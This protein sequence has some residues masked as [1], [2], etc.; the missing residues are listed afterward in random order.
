MTKWQTVVKKTYYNKFIIFVIP[1]GPTK[2]F[3]SKYS[4]IQIILFSLYNR[5]QII[6]LKTFQVC[7]THTLLFSLLWYRQTSQNVMAPKHATL[8]LDSHTMGVS[9]IKTHCTAV[10]IAMQAK[11]LT[12]GDIEMP[13]VLLFCFH[14]AFQKTVQQT[15]R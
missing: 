6:A 8:I 11:L 3:T 10:K 15:C 12:L 13:K 5:S 7:F 2:H 9:V 14:S 4:G 1:F